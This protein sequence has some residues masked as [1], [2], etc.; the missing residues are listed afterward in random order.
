MPVNVQDLKKDLEKK[1]NR[2]DVR[3]KPKEARNN[4]KKE[5]PDPES[6]LEND[7]NFWKKLRDGGFV[8]YL[9]KDNEYIPLIEFK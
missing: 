2:N 4:V 7:K 3:T 9:H 1:I 5:K 8:L 6:N